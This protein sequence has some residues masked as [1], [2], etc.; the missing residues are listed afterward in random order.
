MPRITQNPAGSELLSRRTRKASDRKHERAHDTLANFWIWYTQ[1]PDSVDAER[2]LEQINRIHAALAKTMPD[3]FPDEDY[4]YTACMLGTSGHNV[5]RKAGHP[6]FSEKQKIAAH[7]FWRAI[8]HKMRG[9]NG[10]IDEFPEDF[11]GMERL[12]ADFDARGFPQTEAGTELAE[13]TISQF[14]EDNFP[15]PLQGFGR[16]MVLTFMEPHIRK[17]RQTGDPNPVAAFFIRRLVRFKLFM[18]DHVLP[19]PKMNLVERAKAAG[20]ND[21]QMKMPRMVPASEVPFARDGRIL[22]PKPAAEKK[23]SGGCPFH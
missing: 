11:E 10:Y 21:R 9:M 22:T 5:M 7:H 1:G 18:A 19:D 4:V 23:S 16:Q 6:G 14:C 8:L 17:L 3:A 13:Y 2:S 20:R 12:V 15:K